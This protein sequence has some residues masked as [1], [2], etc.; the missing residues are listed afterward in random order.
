MSEDKYINVI[1]Q[2]DNAT[3]QNVS[4]M[5]MGPAGSESSG[6][7]G[8]SGRYKDVGS[9]MD[10]LPFS[11]QA[12][13]SYGVVNLTNKDSRPENFSFG[14]MAGGDGPERA[15]P[16]Q[17][18]IR[19][20]VKL[21]EALAANSAGDG[22]K[23]YSDPPIEPLA[24]DRFLATLQ[25]GYQ[26]ASNTI[27]GH[28]GPFG[29]IYDVKR[30]LRQ[31]LLEQSGLT[32]QDV[33]IAIVDTGIN[34]KYL[35]AKGQLGRI[36]NLRSWN[37]PGFPTPGNVNLYLGSNN[38]TTRHG[39]MCAFAASILAPDATFLDFPLLYSNTLLSDALRA[40]NQMRVDYN[41]PSWPYQ[42]LVINNSW[43]Y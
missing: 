9:K 26:S 40:Y 35:K 37:E 39:T 31:D 15:S 13:M 2:I 5:V 36:D 14:A 23:L 34:K 1:A 43:G 33:A 7:E 8:T 22:T 12:D 19:G 3:T 29:S 17:K 18:I 25:G 10:S 24:N 32:G 41:S 16:G 21:S 27:C 6:P 20:K 11:F 28:T 42:G 30:V 38:N 4:N